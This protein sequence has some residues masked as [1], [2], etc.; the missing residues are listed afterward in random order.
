MEQT[1]QAVAAL[2]RSVGKSEKNMLVWVKT[3]WKKPDITMLKTHK[4]DVYIDVNPD[5]SIPCQKSRLLLAHT[6]LQ[7]CQRLTTRIQLLIFQVFH[8][9]FRGTVYFMHFRQFCV[10]I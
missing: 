6:G 9:S 8:G 7:L 2:R 3:E 10:D 4:T 1:T 5:D